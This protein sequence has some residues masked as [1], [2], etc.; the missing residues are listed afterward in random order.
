MTMHLFAESEPSSGRVVHTAATSFVVQN[1]M[2]RSWM[3]HNLEE[4]TPACTKLPAALRM[5]S[6]GKDQPAQELHETAF[7]V[8]FKEQLGEGGSFW[9]FIENDGEG[10]R[11][12]Y[13][14][15]QF[16]EAMQVVHQVTPLHTTK[17]ISDGFDWASLGEGTVVDVSRPFL[18]PR[19]FITNPSPRSGA[20]PDTKPL[21]SQGSFLIS[22]WLF[23]TAQ[24]SKSLS[25]T[26]SHRTLPLVSPFKRTTFSRS[27]PSLQTSTL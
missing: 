24:K 12:G 20:R 15:K 5:Y 2:Y 8:E 25:R 14:T 17:L 6:Q 1:P 21:H 4:V 11:K 23:R 27:S 16:S 19:S 3:S 13:R 22:S 7:A 18:S 10:D 26:T 9:D